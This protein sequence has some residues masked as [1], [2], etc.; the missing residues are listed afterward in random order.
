MGL[1]F[2]SICVMQVSIY[3][4]EAPPPIRDVSFSSFPPPMPLAETFQPIA[5]PQK[6]RY[7]FLAPPSFLYVI[8]TFASIPT[9]LIRAS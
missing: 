2:V 6:P 1:P 5:L 3:F 8:L 4:M 7:V 9:H